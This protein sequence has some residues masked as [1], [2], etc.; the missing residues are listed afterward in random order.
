ML[1][2]GGSQMLLGAAQLIAQLLLYNQFSVMLGR[3]WLQPAQALVTF[4]QLLI[5]MRHPCLRLSQ[6]LMT[7]RH[8][9]FSCCQ[10]FNR[11]GI[12]LR[13]LGQAILTRLEQLQRLI[14]RPRTLVP[15]EIFQLRG[16][17]SH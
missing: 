5:G 13:K 16:E 3:P 1:F 10:R 11:R 17:R 2:Q 4:A 9:R 8:I 7:D 14:Q 6:L 15:F 12:V